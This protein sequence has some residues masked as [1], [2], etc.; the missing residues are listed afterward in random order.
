MT[1]SP[2]G[3]MR[4]DRLGPCALVVC[5]LLAIHTGLRAPSLWS[6]QYYVPD[7]AS[8]F[9]RRG[10][11]GTLLLPLGDQRFHYLPIVVVQLLVFAALA[12]GAVR[13][14][15]RADR[16]ARLLMALFLLGPAGGFLFHTLGYVDHLL[17]LLLLAAVRVK[18]HG[19]AAALLASSLLVHEMALFFTVPLFVVF[20]TLRTGR[21]GPALLGFGAALATFASIYLFFQVPDPNDVQAFVELL[22]GK[23]D[24]PLRVDYYHVF[25]NDFQARIGLYYWHLDHNFG[26]HS[27]PLAGLALLGCA[28][29]GWL[30]AA[31]A[32]LQPVGAWLERV[33]S[34]RTQRLLFGVAC[35][36]A[37]AAP[38]LLGLFGWDVYRWIF[39]SLA[40][41]TATAVL[42]ASRLPPGHRARRIGLFGLAIVLLLFVVL[43]CGFGVDFVYFDQ[44]RPRPWNV[45]ALRHVW[46]HELWDELSRIPK[47]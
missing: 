3:T 9:V 42:L 20:R 29:V 6:V 43:A 19:A 28:V 23:T 35:A 21:P 30:G 16:P 4:P 17:V 47:Y 13:M 8:G 38:L 12:W 36:A 24:Y 40:S 15:Q 5:L 14:V 22:R 41:A 44:Y 37:C 18:H 34:A 26:S 1:E 32:P 2:S 46:T 25:V 7:F 27:L 10:L 45:E 39:L 11:A 33:L 31:V